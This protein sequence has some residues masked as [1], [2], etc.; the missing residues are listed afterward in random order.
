[1]IKT[2]IKLL[3]TL[4]VLNA[5][6]RG[7]LTAWRHY[8][9]KDA[10]QQLILFGNDVSM[11]QL[12]YLILDEAAEL[13]VPVEPENIDIS[14]VGNRTAVY[15]S[16]TTPVEFFPGFTYPVDLSFEVEVLALNPSNADKKA[17]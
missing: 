13:N 6:A 10:A 4:A 2:V 16:Y 17:R 14:R 3:I 15:V 7:G 1:L 11:A 12:S 5:I 9:L 8:E